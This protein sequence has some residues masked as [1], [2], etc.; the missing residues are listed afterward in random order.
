M[1]CREFEGL[2]P[3]LGREPASQNNDLQVALSHAKSCGRC[4][5]RLADER[6]LLEGLNALAS[7]SKAN[8][9]PLRLET[10][11]LKAFRE[12]GGKTLP[13]IP[14]IAP[15]S[16]GVDSRAFQPKWKWTLK[17]AGLAASVLLLLGWITARQP[18]LRKQESVN[19]RNVPTGDSPPAVS[20]NQ[21]AI[22]ASP[23]AG[24]VTKAS[25]AKR[26][27]G[28]K[29]QPRSFVPAPDP[30]SR[31]EGREGLEDR[32][33]RT[34]F[35]PFMAVEPLSPS[36]L[37]QLVRIRLPRSAVQVFGLPVNM[38]RSREPVEADVLLGEDGRAL[39][40]RFVKQ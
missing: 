38:E 17:Y 33:I 21:V 2:L 27:Q 3:V 13:S 28:R 1:N 35:I 32:E 15:L 20:P 24:E 7:E 6:A 40:V 12:A 9:P 37:R 25:A 31:S 36:E 23:F 30:V 14:E 22:E 18:G 4:S 10:A 39:A 5:A 8:L 26:K 29:A 16:T 11:L 34:A 19:T